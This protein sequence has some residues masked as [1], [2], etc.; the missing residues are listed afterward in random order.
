MSHT[1]PLACQLAIYPP[2]VPAVQRS[3]GRC[4]GQTLVWVSLDIV[5]EVDAGKLEPMCLPCMDTLFRG[6][7][8]AYVAL[9][10]AQ[11]DLL[12]EMGMLGWADQFTTDINRRKR[13]ITGEWVPPS[14]T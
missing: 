3:C 5:A 11:T 9:T 7:P 12:A 4:P 13:R 6:D 2:T 10:S 8:E 1:T 14:G